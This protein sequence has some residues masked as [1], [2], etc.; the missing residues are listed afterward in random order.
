MEVDLTCSPFPLVTDNDS[1]IIPTPWDDA[2][3][4]WAAVLAMLQ[5]QR[6]KDAQV[7]LEMFKAEMP[8]CASVVCPQMIQNTYGATIRSA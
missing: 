8:F 4:W 2:V 5:Q 1:E 7:M 3:V 6:P